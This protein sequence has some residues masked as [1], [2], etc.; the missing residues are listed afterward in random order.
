MSLKEVLEDVG[1]GE[2]EIATY[3]YLLSNPSTT[4]LAIAKNTKIDRTTIYDMLNKLIRKGLVSYHD[5]KRTKRFSA[6]SPEQL[7]AQYRIKYESLES[8]IPHLKQAA[9]RPD[10]KL[11]CDVFTEREGILSVLTGLINETKEY[12][13]IG[14]RKE[15]EQLLSYFNEKGLL[16]LEEKSIKERGIADSAA[17]F[18]KAKN[19][20]QRK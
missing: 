5:E 1:L 3:L 7:L 8:I 20:A 17:T 11:T 18:K 4:A 2:K 15:Y 6:A 12:H 19:G 10:N 16:L 14:I 9:A 13:V